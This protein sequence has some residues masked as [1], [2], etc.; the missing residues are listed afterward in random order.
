[1]EPAISYPQDFNAYS[2][3]SGS[4]TLPLRTK[5]LTPIRTGTC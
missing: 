4:L 5:A 1:M 2:L 3:H